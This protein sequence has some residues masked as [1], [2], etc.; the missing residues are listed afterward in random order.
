MPFVLF[1]AGIGPQELALACGAN[2]A[3]VLGLGQEV[4]LNNASEETVQE[5]KVD[6]KEN[7]PRRF[8]LVR[9]ERIF[10]YKL[11]YVEFSIANFLEFN[12]YALGST[13]SPR[14]CSVWEKKTLRIGCAIRLGLSIAGHRL[15]LKLQI[16]PIQTAESK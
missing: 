15:N 9:L 3:Q 10:N 14:N 13:S 16:L 7:P 2:D 8:D 6:L 11:E 5:T 1:P 4:G 12:V